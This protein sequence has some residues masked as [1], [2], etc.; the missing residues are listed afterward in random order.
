MTWWVKQQTNGDESN[1]TLV[2][3]SFLTHCH[4]RTVTLSCN[5]QPLTAKEQ[6]L[7]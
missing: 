4:A 3:S 7:L 5:Q 2:L 6:H 1:T